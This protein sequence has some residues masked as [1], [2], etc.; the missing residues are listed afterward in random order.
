MVSLQEERKTFLKTLFL[1]LVVFV[2]LCDS[3]HDL[4]HPLDPALPL[5]LLIGFVIEGLFGLAHC[6]LPH[7]FVEVEVVERLV[8]V[9]GEEH[10]LTEGERQ[11]LSHFG[12][13]SVNELVEF[14]QVS[15]VES[16]CLQ[17]AGLAVGADGDALRVD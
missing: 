12:E 5:C 16:E 9:F 1:L 4:L 15:G 6:G 11:V 17:Q 3:Q 14:A 10:S 13:D 8:V 7:L 2:I